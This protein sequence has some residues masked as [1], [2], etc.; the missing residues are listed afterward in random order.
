MKAPVRTVSPGNLRYRALR[1]LSAR[2]LR[3]CTHRH[4][5]IGMWL[6]DGQGQC[7]AMNLTWPSLAKKFDLL[8][9]GEVV[10]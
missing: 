1:T 9:A 6:I 8:E 4:S 5:P 10:E 7:V 2:G 3:L